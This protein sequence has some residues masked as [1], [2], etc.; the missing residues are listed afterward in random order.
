MVAV[1]GRST[2]LFLATSRA[3]MSPIVAP[4]NSVLIP[5]AP[6]T[7][8]DCLVALSKMIDQGVQ[9]QIAVIYASPH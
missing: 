9:V 2:A 7:F 8:S 4:M 6:S 5:L 3:K 1:S